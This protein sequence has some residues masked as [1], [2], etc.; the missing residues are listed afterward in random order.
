MKRNGGNDAVSIDRTVED[1]L[2]AVLSYIHE[3]FFELEGCQ[4]QKPAPSSRKVMQSKP[5]T[6]FSKDQTMNLV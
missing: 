3:T 2:S 6:A 5:T 1:K 4:P